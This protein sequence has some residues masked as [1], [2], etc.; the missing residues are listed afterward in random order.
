MV[1]KVMMNKM[2][3]RL[4]KMNIMGVELPESQLHIAMRKKNDLKMI[5]GR[6]SEN[7]RIKTFF[8]V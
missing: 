8:L 6:Q 7:K 2:S 3:E 4:K 1:M 5:K